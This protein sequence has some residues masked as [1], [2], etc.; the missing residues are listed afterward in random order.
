[1]RRFCSQQ[2]ITGSEVLLTG[3]EAHHLLHVNRVQVGESVILFDGTSGEYVAKVVEA[4]KTSARLEIVQRLGHNRMPAT[5]ITL[6]TAIAK[7][8]RMDVLVQMTCELG[9]GTLVPVLTSR[10][11]VKPG[12]NKVEHWR[13]IVLESCKQSGRNLLMTIENPLPL[14]DAV[15]QPRTD[16][17]KLLLSTAQD[18]R[19]IADL[20]NPR[21]KKV[22]LLVGPEG[23][24]TE[25]ELRAAEGAGFLPVSLG[26]ST[27][28][29]ETAAVCA[30]AVVLTTLG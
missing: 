2:P 28:R 9:V 11:V 29:I 26:Q 8:S 1:M 6:L 19:P 23:G 27:L 25:D 17:L 24:F 12:A 14:C 16:T 18:V 20:L 7:G 5:D 22:A 10:S 21:P 15:V 30:S 3:T 4:S 13:R